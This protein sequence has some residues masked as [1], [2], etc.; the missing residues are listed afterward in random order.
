ML[1][2][3]VFDRSGGEV[4]SMEID[5]AEFGGEVNRQ[6]LHDV[7]VMYQAN[8]RQ[9]TVR[10]KN[11]AEVAGSGKKMYR[12]KGTGN[13]RMGAKRTGKRVGGG[14]THA[15]RPRDFSYTMPKKMVRAA[16]RMALLSK[17][18]DNEATVVE[19]LSFSEPKT[20]E[21]AGVLRALKLD[22]QSC[23]IALARHD[24]NLWKSARNIPRVKVSPAAELNALDL[25]TQK[26]LLITREALESLR[27]QA[28]A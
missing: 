15:K 14:M 10:T 20:R 24:A 11:R 4:G 28:T 23:L 17:L 26:R 5:P 1:T 18:L 13:A 27:Q 12:Q 25:L 3:P 7:I 22:G 19:G 16:T 8:R 2:L 6:L 9:G 21:M